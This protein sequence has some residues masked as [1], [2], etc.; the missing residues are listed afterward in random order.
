MLRI[1]PDLHMALERLRE[2]QHKTLTD[3]V[4][5]FVEERGV[6]RTEP[7]SVERRWWTIQPG[8]GLHAGGMTIPNDARLRCQYRGHVGY[9]TVV[10]D[11]VSFGDAP[12][13]S[14]PGAARAFLAQ[15]GVTGPA[16][17][18]D[19]IK[20]WGMEYP[21]NSGQWR[22]LDS[23]RRPWQVKRHRR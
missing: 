18:R 17:N 14:L 8:E 20:F 13:D 21:A 16:A 1:S 19:G 23:F 22:R 7:T 9:A 12:Y 3:L 4:W 15:H 6:G 10:E 5:Q 11:K 2:P